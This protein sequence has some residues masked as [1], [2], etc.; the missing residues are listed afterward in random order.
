M[1][2]R[3][4]FT[5]TV[6]AATAAPFVNRATAQATDDIRSMIAGMNQLHSLQIQLGDEVVFAAAPRGA[7]LD[8]MANIKSCSKSLVALLLGSAIDRGEIADVT[9]RLR[10]VAPALIP[11]RAT[12]GVGSITMQ[13]FVTLSAGLEGTSGAGYGRW[14]SSAN[15]VADALQRP[16]VDTPGG[17]MIYSTG[18]THVLGAA[19]ALATGQSLL[20]LAR[21]RLGAPLG[22]EIPAWTRDPQGNYLG[23]NDMALTPRA[24]LRIGVMM[25][26]GGRYA[27]AQVV[28]EAW[29]RAS[30]IAR[31]R[32][33]WSG[34]GYGYGWFLSQSGYV[35]ARGFGGQLI[36]ANPG[37]GLAVAITSGLER[38]ARSQGYFGEQM[39]L[40]DGPVLALA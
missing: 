25:R 22:I 33:P 11:P 23:G 37:R 8:R 24:M 15:W 14:V 36:A 40:L 38:P 29:M 34:L 20:A 6:I 4:A 9:A 1:I 26:D 32:S 17:R 27:G 31:T 21:A 12:A 5:A 2:S 18:T 7:G 16:M 35:I 3:R 39:A 19:I 30:L 13:D 28:S 10:D